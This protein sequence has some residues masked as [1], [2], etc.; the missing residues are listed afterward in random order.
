MF[1]LIIRPVTSL[2]LFLLISMLH[3]GL[4]DSNRLPPLQRLVRVLG[5]GE[6][7]GPTQNIEHMKHPTHNKHNK[8][9]QHQNSRNTHNL[10]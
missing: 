4:G 2:T 9:E 7:M 1:V 6:N 5:E 10:R 8:H 3:F